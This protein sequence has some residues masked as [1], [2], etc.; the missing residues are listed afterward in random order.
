MC[1]IFA[2]INDGAVTQ[3]LIAGLQALSYRGYDSAGIAV[4][5]TQG[6]QRRRAGGKLN[7]LIELL[8]EQPLDGPIGIAHTR[9]A[10]HGQPTSGNAH[11]HMTEQVAVAHNGI[12][13]NYRELRLDL[14]ADGYRFES[15]TDSEV[16]PLLLTRYLDRGFDN[17]QALRNTIEQL[18][19]SFALVAIF[20]NL[21]DTLYAARRAS[22]LVLG[23]G[24]QGFYLASDENALQGHAS[25]TCHLEDG[26]LA[27]VQQRAYVVTD[28][29]GHVL[30]R[31]LQELVPLNEPIV[32]KGGYRHFM[33][34]EI[35]EQPAV[36]SKTIAQHLVTTAQGLALAPLPFAAA[37]VQ[38]LSIIACGTSLFAGQ[39]ARYWLERVAGV[40]TDTDIASEFR[41]RQAPIDASC[42]ALFISQSGETADTLA[43]MRYAHEQGQTCLAI[44]NQM[45][46]SMATEADIMLPTLAGVEVGVASTK[47]F[48]AQLA[49]LLMLTLNL[50][51]ANHR[52]MDDEE[53]RILQAITA[54][55]DT[56]SA[57]LEDDGMPGLNAAAESLKNASSVLYLGR[58]IAFPLAQEGALKLK[59]ISYI[60][61]EAYPAGELKHGPIALIDEHMPVIML[62]PPGALADKTLSNLREIHA[63]GAKIIL[64]SDASGIQAAEGFIEHGIC[65]PSVEEVLQPLIYSLPLQLLAYQV[66]LLKGTDV[67][68][69]RN[70]AKSVTVE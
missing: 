14:E 44:V 27:C 56:M 2:A 31:P 10:T 37:Q 58:G 65:M 17:V 18:E 51:R 20:K 36:I 35:H 61:A 38:R 42:K 69:P 70:L 39:V 25:H 3:G 40:P 12:I 30:E 45:R 28:R 8:A 43:A 16:I 1:G 48:T 60:H 22:P 6:L 21:P 23:Q 47:A 67:D 33:L 66:A 13:E 41:Y 53:Q 4:M 24:E 9:W 64:I 7:C 55:P 57:L 34:K 11:P 5:N 68:Q 26:D 59:E 15:E 46:S 49:A 32:D 29:R 19:G 52:L 54:L 62:A 63:R 50:A